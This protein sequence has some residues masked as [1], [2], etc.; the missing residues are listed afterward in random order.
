M[1]IFV[2]LYK[3]LATP[4]YW[5]ITLSFS[6]RVHFPC[7][8][9]PLAMSSQNIHRISRRLRTL[10]IVG[11]YV[12]LT[13]S[14][15]RPILIR[16]FCFKSNWPLFEKHGNLLFYTSNSIHI[17]NIMERF[18]SKI[19]KIDMQIS[20]NTKELLQRFKSWLCNVEYRKPTFEIYCGIQFFLLI[21]ADY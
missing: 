20:N 3:F 4:L 19:F 12:L 8:G 7:W 13:L 17:A 5:P 14:T 2:P 9:N 15:R 10:G 1:N 6:L 18:T 16:L 21:S 11:L